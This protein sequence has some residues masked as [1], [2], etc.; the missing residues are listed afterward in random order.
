MKW[1]FGIMR[2]N[3]KDCVDRSTVYSSL[4]KEWLL[5]L[6]I[7]V[8]WTIIGQPAI[9]GQFFSELECS[10]S[11]DMA[12]MSRFCRQWR[13]KPSAFK[14]ISSVFQLHNTSVTRY[15]SLSGWPAPSAWVPPNLSW[16]DSRPY[17]VSQ[18][19]WQRLQPSRRTEITCWWS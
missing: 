12:Q 9:Q 1:T 7:W 11:S 16:G 13:L 15:V 2:Y 4:W 3:N 17:T 10:L 8:S 19:T 5:L 6:L 14:T 18:F